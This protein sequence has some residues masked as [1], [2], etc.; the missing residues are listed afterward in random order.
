MTSNRRVQ[1]TCRMAEKDTPLCPPRRRGLRAACK[2]LGLGLALAFVV[3]APG[4]AQTNRPFPTYQ[5]SAVHEQQQHTNSS[6]DDLNDRL[7]GE[8]EK[9]WHALNAQRQKAMV[10]D[11]AKLLQLATELNAEVAAGNSE[12]L[13]PSELRKVAAIEKLARSVKEKMSLAVGG[14]L[15]DRD[16]FRVPGPRSAGSP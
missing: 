5:G 10:S 16:P 11:A 9:Q 14:G 13:T 7:P 4:M 8:R 6:L 12:S 15:D 2:T 1:G 3:A